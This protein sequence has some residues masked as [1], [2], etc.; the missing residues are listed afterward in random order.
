MHL[1]FDADKSFSR[2]QWIFGCGLYL[3]KRSDVL[4]PKDVILVVVYHHRLQTI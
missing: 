1:T 4:T 2:I 3:T